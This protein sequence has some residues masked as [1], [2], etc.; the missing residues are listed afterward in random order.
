[1]CNTR[2]PSNLYWTSFVRTQWDL[3]LRA[4]DVLAITTSAY[5][6]AGRLW[7]YE[8]KTHKSGW[9]TLRPS[10][11]EAIASC[12][13]ANPGRSLIWPGLKPRSFYRAFSR[14]AAAACLPGTSRWLRSGS[15]SAVEKANPGQGWR[16]LNHSG[17]AVFEKHYRIDK[18]CQPESIMPPEIGSGPDGTP[19]GKDGAA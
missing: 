8:H 12:L 19:G 16:F 11:S 9:H 13:A 2:I 6:R 4:G 10:T 15:S 14:L 3:G 17:P 18:V 7:V 1:M 5:D